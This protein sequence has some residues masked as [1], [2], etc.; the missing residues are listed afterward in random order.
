MEAVIWL[1]GTSFQIYIW[2]LIAHV[3]V[4]LLISFKVLDTRHPVVHQIGRFLWQ[5]TEPLLG[6]I[7]RLLNKVLGNLGGIDLSP[8]IAIVL[9]QFLSMFIIGTILAPLAYGP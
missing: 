9:L 6:P 7:R 8:L 5:V 3:I 4:S 2:I 1:V